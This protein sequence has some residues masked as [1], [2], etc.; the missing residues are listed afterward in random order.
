MLWEKGGVTDIGNL[1]AQWWNTP[2]AINQRGD[3]VGFAGD[4]AFPEGDILHGFI[5]TRSGGIRPLGALPGHI[6]SEAYGINERRQVVGVS[7]DADF[8]DC[9]A[10]IWENG[11]MKDLND[12]KAPGFSARLEQGKDIN[13]RGEITG[14][15]IDPTTSVRTAFLAV[16]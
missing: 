9:R 6:H 7:C 3:V 12:L 13:E 10:F 16:P 8:V 4:P 14:R 15:A 1:G 5:W 11:V 2:T